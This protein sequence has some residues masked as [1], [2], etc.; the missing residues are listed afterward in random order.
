MIVPDLATLKLSLGGWL[1][2]AHRDVTPT[3]SRPRSRTRPAAPN[4][5][6]R[7]HGDQLRLLGDTP[8]ELGHTTFRES[9]ARPKRKVRQRARHDERIVAQDQRGY[10]GAKSTFWEQVDL[11]GGTRL[12]R[13][14]IDSNN[15][16]YTGE[17]RWR[18]RDLPRGLSLLRPARQSRPRGGDGTAAGTVFNDQ[19]LGIHVPKDPKTGFVDLLTRSDR[20]V[21]QRQDR[22][23][24][25]AAVR[26]FRLSPGA[27]RGTRAPRRVVTDGRTALLSRDGLLRVRRAG[28]GR[29]HRR[30]PAAQALR[31]RELRPAPR[32][33][34]GRGR[35]RLGRRLLQDRRRPD[36][37]PGD[38]EPDRPV[39]VSVGALS[40]V[41][42]Q[43][44]PRAA[45]RR[46]DGAAQE[47]RLPGL[48]FR[49]YFTIGGNFTYID[50][51]VDRTDAELQR[52]TVVLRCHP[53]DDRDLPGAQQDPASVRP[54]G[55]DRERRPHLRPAGVGNPG[56]R[57]VLR[58][59][60]RPR[61]CRRREPQLRATRSS[62][63]PSTATS[64]RTRVST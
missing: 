44:Q 9:A 38:P 60:R 1:E 14:Q 10:I 19:V 42:Q 40:D 2:N 17:D 30:Q 16:P 43:S 32:V 13:I 24:T 61:R 64:T 59:Q 57:R 22:R 51:K 35:P 58:D 27:H 4:G 49:Q 41:L 31:R 63:S 5:R 20:L 34:V 45:R 7:R 52:S 15:S 29:P 25:L 18:A 3:S 26:G 28:P 53:R 46:R 48:R 54:A 56:D 55:V 62:R 6:L 11:L 50:A 33:H 47:P 12:E 36:R 8:N 37:E 23:D 21:D 39:H